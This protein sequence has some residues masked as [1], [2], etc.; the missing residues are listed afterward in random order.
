MLFRSGIAYD[1]LTGIVR[2]TLIQNG[3]VFSTS[4][5]SVTFTGS[6]FVGF[7]GATGTE[8]ETIEIGEFSFGPNNAPIA[9]DDV[10]GLAGP[11]VDVKPLANDTDA[12]SA[13]GDTLFVSAVGGARFG[14]A[15]RIDAGTIRYTPGADFPGQDT[16]T[17]T[18][19]DFGGAIATA[20]VVVSRDA[21]AGIYTDRK[22]V[23]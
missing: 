13:A 16:F 18:V 7:T 22:S 4:T 19:Q 6:Q 23:V 15:E 11:F 17:Y 21:G 5:Q 8:S 20:N 2:V 3:N 12:D 14:A 9:N 1:A 10:A